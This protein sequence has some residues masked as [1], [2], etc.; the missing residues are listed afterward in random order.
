MTYARSSGDGENNMMHV[1]IIAP[2]SRRHPHVEIVDTS[3]GPRYTGFAIDTS[4]FT[5]GSSKRLLG[6]RRRLDLPTFF[7]R[8]RMK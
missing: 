4:R 1:E 6:M 2:A 8:R 5:T 3:D 7:E